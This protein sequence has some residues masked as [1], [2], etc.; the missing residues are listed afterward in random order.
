MN[1]R[2]KGIRKAKDYLK[3]SGLENER[4]LISKAEMR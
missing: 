4:T 2:D 1:V 3:I